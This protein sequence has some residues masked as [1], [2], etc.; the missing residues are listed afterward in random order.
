MRW[1]REAR[2]DEDEL[3]DS[4]HDEILLIPVFNM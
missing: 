2:R 3:S 4:S 1:E